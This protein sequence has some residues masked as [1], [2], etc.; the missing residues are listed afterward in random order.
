MGFKST[1]ATKWWIFVQVLWKLTFSRGKGAQ[2][3]SYPTS[4]PIDVKKTHEPLMMTHPGGVSYYG[5]RLAGI[6]PHYAA[7]GSERCFHIWRGWQEER[8][9]WRFWQFFK[10]FEFFFQL[11]QIIQKWKEK[12]FSV[13]FSLP[14]RGSDLRIIICKKLQQCCLLN[15]K[16][17][18]PFALM[19]LLIMFTS[20][21]C[22]R[23][24]RVGS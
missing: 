20:Y 1:V 13:V 10:I 8:F 24:W 16:Q 19:P 5:G 15:K 17:R 11:P 21:L 4:S 14:F 2:G 22:F 6:T 9:K 3:F 23:V 12:Q 18:K 7:A